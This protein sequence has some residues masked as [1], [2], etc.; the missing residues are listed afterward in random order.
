MQYKYIFVEVYDYVTEQWKTARFFLYN[1]EV[2]TPKETTVNTEQTTKEQETTKVPA[3]EEP[4][5]TVA[6]TEA[7]K[8]KAPAKAKIKKVTPKKKAS[9]VVKLSIKKVKGAN[10]YQVQISKTKKFTKKNIL[11]NKKSVKKLKPSIKSKKLKNKKKL[12][13]RVRAYA[14]DSN[15]KKIYGKWSKVKGYN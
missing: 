4:V 10:G 2:E 7:Q 11:V 5:T 13:V 14:V 12:F 1:K 9:K 6:P 15:G 3:I 8:V